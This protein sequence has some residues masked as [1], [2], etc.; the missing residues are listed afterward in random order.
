MIAG[1]L[2]YACMALADGCGG[3]DGMLH[4]RVTDMTGAVMSGVTVVLQRAD[5]AEQQVI[6]DDTGAYAFTPLP[7]GPHR[8]LVRAVNFADARRE[9]VTGAAPVRV[10]VVLG[11]AL[12]ASVTVTARGTVRD[13]ADVE[14]PREHLVEL[15]PSASVGT[16]TARQVDARPIARAGEVL[17]TVPGLVATQHSGEGKANQYYLRGFN[18]DHGTDFATTVAGV[19]VNMP[20]HAHGHGYADVNFL[21]PELITSVQYRKGPYFADQ[22]D[23]SAA[24]A[25]N[26]NYANQLA[27]GLMEVG[28]GAGGWGRALIAGSRRVGGAD[29]LY[30]FEGNRN[31]GPWERPEDHR[32]GNAVLRY[33]RDRGSGS[34]S[35]TAMAYTA[36]WN[37]TDQVP[38]RAIR[39]GRLSRF[40]SFDASDGGRTHR[41]SVSSEAEWGSPAGGTE[42]SAYVLD[43][44][45]DL[46]SNFTYA[47]DDPQRG[48]QFQQVDDRRV[49]G[50]RLVHRRLGRWG[51]VETAHSFG[52]VVRHD[53]IGLV[54]L[55]RTQNRRRHSTVRE[56][57]VSQSS[58]AGFAQTELRP[59]PWLRA[60][61]GLR[62]D[63]FR[64]DVRGDAS[65]NAAL[66]SPKASLVVGPWAGTEVYV[67]G[68]RGFHSNDARA[69]TDGS[70]SD[71][72]PLVR[73]DGAEL[74]LR[75]VAFPGVQMTMAVWA[76]TL[77]SEL[78]FVGDAGATAAGRPSRRS[79]VEWSAHARPTRWLELEGDVALSRAKFTDA[80]AEGSHVPGAVG[81]VASA[82][83]SVGPTAAVSGGL[84]WRYVGPRP[85]TESA[86]VMSEATGLLSGQL[87]YAFNRRLRVR[88]DALNLLNSAAS[89]IEYFYTSR[90]PGEPAEGIEDIHTHP[91][92]PR[93]VRISLGVGF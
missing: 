21:I 89:D 36:S 3:Q 15:P 82:G 69:A 14:R 86:R 64:F 8:L 67:N 43:Y 80:A 9:V 7:E 38:A 18:L 90:L 83:F 31:D 46:F 23:F 78:V 75:T 58:V 93:S 1:L 6:T 30:A 20:T 22:G 50:G 76:L 39:A 87:G 56:D 59:A 62:V 84:R 32:R 88:L 55:Y 60:I 65:R 72:R 61:G 26:I 29:V 73:A 57:A 25:A 81:V 33:S 42:V 11:I 70:T 34:F 19:P 54:G 5:G 44:A 35:L 63:G 2:V 85:L 10:D 77:E 28:A 52:A 66:L 27:E 49:V 45:L 91:V 37:A 16:V 68:G 12:T 79:G 41:L 40:G 71:I 47:L 74:G 17:E 13:L 4:G 24:G 48:D 53:A 92:P 51:A